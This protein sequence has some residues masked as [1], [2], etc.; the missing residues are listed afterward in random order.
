MHRCIPIDSDPLSAAT[1]AADYRSC[2]RFADRFG[3]PSIAALE[4]GRWRAA[5]A[6][7]PGTIGPQEYFGEFAHYKWETSLYREHLV[8]TIMS[9]WESEADI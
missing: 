8:E 7:L 9:A 5:S 4:A 2:I 6:T 3:N 1:S